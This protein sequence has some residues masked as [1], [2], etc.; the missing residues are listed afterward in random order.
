M[1]GRLGRRA[2]SM[3][4]ALLVVGG[5]LAF[6]AVPGDAAI[7]LV[8]FIYGL[9]CALAVF[10]VAQR[11]PVRVRTA[12]LCIATGIAAAVAGDGVWAFDEIV[13]DRL[14]SF[15]SVADGLYLAGYPLQM[16]GLWV[17]LRGRSTRS[18][19]GTLH[20]A[21]VVT[22]GAASLSW[23]FIMRSS[24]LDGTLTFF[25]RAVSLSYPIAD[26]LLLAVAV[27][28]VLS[29]GTR[30]AADL[31]FTAALLTSLLA[32]VVYSFQTASDTYRSGAWVDS[33]WLLSYGCWVL[34]ALRTSDAAP[35]V[36]SDG[37]TEVTLG[38]LRIAFLAVSALLAPACLVFWVDQRSAPDLLVVAA[39][40]AVAFGLVMS[41]LVV[42]L[43][44][45]AVANSLIAQ[46]QLDRQ[47]LL[48]QVVEAAE[49]ERIR[50]A[51]ELHDGP[52]QALSALGFD[53]ELGLLSLAD[54]DHADVDAIIRRTASTISNEVADI[55]QL[56]AALRPPILDE[57]GIAFAIEEH[58]R[59]VAQRSGLQITCTTP[60]VTSVEPDV[61]TALYRVTQEALSNIQ[62]HAAARQVD[63]ELSI[64][65]RM[66]TLTVTDDGTGFV[67]P[68]TAD[69]LRD[70]HYGLAGIAERAAMAGGSMQLHTEPGR[71]TRLTFSLPANTV[72]PAIGER[73]HER[74]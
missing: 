39:L 68:S 31:W 61:E 38:P 35:P 20:D 37:H 36:P 25:E 33:V 65:D 14:T 64:A 9:V 12:L 16:L 10:W 43:R 54:G 17:L 52:V 6:Q 7:N 55:R 62:R 8:Y 23:T 5:S 26:V 21:A 19:S 2:S 70:G 53:L 63:I 74:I 24:A 34:G 67:V 27:R 18:N 51:A 40:S 28:L 3:L 60:P 32:D 13:R 69:L 4:P 66:A 29:P 73:Q 72:H 30:R 42:A 15:P 22:C 45:L 41:R 50:V 56:M 11:S 48:R 1:P 58:A 44:E 57:G 46:A 47:R 71:G 49:H 59:N